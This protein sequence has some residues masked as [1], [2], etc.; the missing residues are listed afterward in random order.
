MSTKVCLD[1]DDMGFGVRTE[2]LENH[3]FIHW[4]NN[5]C[6]FSSGNNMVLYTKGSRIL[7]VHNEPFREQNA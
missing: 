3:V 5:S 1:R 7:V 6:A 4:W 2:A